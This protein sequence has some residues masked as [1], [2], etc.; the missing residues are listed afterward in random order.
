MRST[1]REA[2][3][4]PCLAV[5]NGWRKFSVVAIAL[6]LLS[7][8]TEASAIFGSKQKREDQLAAYAESMAQGHF[9]QAVVV[10]EA[11]LTRK[12]R[13]KEK[14]G[15]VDGRALLTYAHIAHA[16]F[17]S[18]QH[19]EAIRRFDQV[20]LAIKQFETRVAGSGGVEAFGAA[21]IGNKVKRYPPKSFD[22]VL[23]NT[24]K[25]IAF[26]ALNRKDDARIEFNRADERTRRAVELFA[27][28]IEQANEAAKDKP[29]VSDDEVQSVVNKHY[30]DLEHWAV[31]EDFVN[32]Y[33]VYMHALYFFAAGQVSSD[34]ENAVTSI[35]RIV[36]MYPGNQTAAADLALFEDVASGRRSRSDI[37]DSVW[38]ICADGIGPELATKEIDMAVKVSN[39]QV[40]VR[41]V[42]PELRINSAGSEG[43]AVQGENG[44]IQAA[45]IAS[46][47]RVF[48]TEFKKRLPLEITQGILSLVVRGAVQSEAQKKGG[49]FG[50]LLGAAYQRE[51][52]S[53]ETRVWLG[54]PKTWYALRVDR[55]ADGVLNVLS[56]QGSPIVSIELPASRFAIAHVRNPGMGARPAT[57]VAVLAESP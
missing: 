34:F 35:E 36:G 12:A 33:T 43:C 27:K 23:V 29:Q 21:L 20:E 48:A 31:Y 2:R 45:E 3:Y 10:A 37:A 22:G 9:E 54:L 18:G 19:D 52:A 15:D 42:L 38:L 13:R 50:Q 53:A 25:A 24:Y 8:S 56:P 28:E 39:Q 51:T 1:L 14:K 30:A 57:D 17:W 16:L 46:M 7:V 26:L 11:T 4:S 40:P 55:P 32:P 47:D 6:A 41:L 49:V 5:L 44:L